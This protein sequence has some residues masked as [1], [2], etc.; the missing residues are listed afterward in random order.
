MLKLAILCQI[1]EN[2]DKTLWS[3]FKFWSNRGKHLCWIGVLALY[4]LWF[5]NKSKNVDL[6]VQIEP[7]IIHSG[8]PLFY[9]F[10]YSWNSIICI[11]I[12]KET[13]YFM[14][15]KNMWWTSYLKRRFESSPFF[16]SPCFNYILLQYI[17]GTQLKSDSQ[18][19]YADLL[20][21]SLILFFKKC[22][23]SIQIIIIFSSSVLCSVIKQDEWDL[24]R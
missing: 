24:H 19:Q 8:H 4:T 17:F 2:S 23:L 12:S 13:N 18:L 1:T 5:W 21:C 16:L 22:T 9:V 15:W 14:F 10:K 20:S 6:G 3:R 7:F 11:V